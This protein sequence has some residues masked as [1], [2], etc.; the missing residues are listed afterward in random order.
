VGATQELIA[1]VREATEGTPYVVEETPDGFTVTIDVV[2]A[3]WYT[4]IRKNG[5]KRVFTYEVRTYDKSRTLSITDV[6]NSVRWN[7]GAGVSSPPSLHAER[8]FKR[9]RVYQLS[10]QKQYGVDAQTRQLTKVV[11]YRF[12]ANEG[13]NI[14]R[15]A[16]SRAGWKERMGAEERGAVIFEGAIVATG[17][18]VGLFF[19]GRAI[20]G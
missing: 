5:L 1:S 13:R 19:L 12:N 8:S 10:F 3:Q 15:D 20:F 11:D 2:D 6:E 9:G 7:A 17:A 14:I 18:L 4:L 16:A